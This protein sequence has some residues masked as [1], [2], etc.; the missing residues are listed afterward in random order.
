MHQNTRKPLY[1]Q[2]FP[3]GACPRIPLAPHA[4]RRV[5]GVGIPPTQGPLIVKIFLGS[6]PPPPHAITHYMYIVARDRTT[7]IVS[8]QNIGHQIRFKVLVLIE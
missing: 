2:N 8:T 7:L 6:P 5:G 1:F 3:V 4:L